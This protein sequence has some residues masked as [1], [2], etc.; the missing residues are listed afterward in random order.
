[1]NSK[2][3]ALCA[4]F[5]VLILKYRGGCVGTESR[6][7]T[8]GGCFLGGSFQENIAEKV[9]SEQESSRQTRGKVRKS[10]PQE[11]EHSAHYE[12]RVLVTA[13]RALLL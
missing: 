10:V 13:G 2:E 11:R 7:S 1:M 9:R 3:R 8:A 12:Q 4:R 5:P 6:A